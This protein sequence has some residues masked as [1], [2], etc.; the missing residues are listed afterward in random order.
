MS[1]ELRIL[2]AL[3]HFGSICFFEVRAV[4]RCSVLTA[5][6]EGEPGMLMTRRLSGEQVPLKAGE[7]LLAPSVELTI[8]RVGCLSE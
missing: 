1:V 6:G 5:K 3:V 8:W 4:C 2:K 7:P